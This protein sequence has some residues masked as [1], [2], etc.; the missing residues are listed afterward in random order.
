[1]LVL[2]IDSPELDDGGS[3]VLPGALSTGFKKALLCRDIC[4]VS[5][6]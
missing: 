5:L 6:P 4:N 2:G 3:V 1:M